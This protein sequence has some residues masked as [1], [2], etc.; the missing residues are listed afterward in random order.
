MMPQ[1]G[2]E[3]PP[4]HCPQPCHHWSWFQTPAKNIPACIVLAQWPH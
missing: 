1:T 2:K 3:E 4:R